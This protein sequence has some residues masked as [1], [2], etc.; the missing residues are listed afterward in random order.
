MDC[1]VWRDDVSAF[2]VSVAFVGACL[3]QIP[4][5]ARCVLAG[6]LDVF[7]VSGGA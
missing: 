5:I 4:D 7:V 1:R 3:R 2:D 6:Y